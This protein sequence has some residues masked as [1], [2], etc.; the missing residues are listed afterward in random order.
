MVSLVV[1]DQ[2]LLHPHQVRHDPLEHLPLGFERLEIF[3]GPPLEQGPPTR[4]QGHALPQLEGVVVGDHDLRPPH[5]VE[6]VVRD[7]LARREVVVR[8]V[9][10]EDAQ[11]VLD[12][13]AGGDDEEATAELLARRPPYG[14][15][16]LPSDQHGHDGGLSCAGGE[17]ESEPAEFGIGVGVGGSEVLD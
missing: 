12:R 11:P 5:L 10:L 16:R 6:H 2:D 17:F 14:V 7:Q 15:H 8:V 3:T 4:G 9:G 1:Q 13:E